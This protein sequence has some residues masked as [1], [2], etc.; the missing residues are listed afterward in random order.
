M[1]VLTD[2]TGF[3]SILFSYISLLTFTFL[4]FCAFRLLK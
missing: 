3:V 1:L 2:G 4:A